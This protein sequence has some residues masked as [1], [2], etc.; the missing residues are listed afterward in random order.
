LNDTPDLNNDGGEG[1]I[2]SYFGSSSGDIDVI[3][4]LVLAQCKDGTYFRLLEGEFAPRAAPAMPHAT[5]PVLEATRSCPQGRGDAVRTENFQLKFDPG[6][7]KYR[8]PAGLD[9]AAAWQAQGAQ[10]LRAA[11]S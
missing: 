11:C 9:L 6:T 10:R 2:L 4:K 3:D 7:T 5:W 8:G 1:A